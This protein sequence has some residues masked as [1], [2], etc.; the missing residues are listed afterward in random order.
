MEEKKKEEVGKK[1]E[2]RTTRRRKKKS[3]KRRVAEGKKGDRSRE[4]GVDC[5]DVHAVVEG[6]T[7][8]AIKFSLA[9]CSAILYDVPQYTPSE[10]FKVNIRHKIMNTEDSF[11]EVV[12][13]FI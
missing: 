1:G 13:H 5:G 3:W 11:L 9:Q 4:R 10:S 2:G 8:T 7:R 12:D 6:N